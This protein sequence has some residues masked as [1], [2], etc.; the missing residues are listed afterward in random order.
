H[1]CLAGGFDLI[2]NNNCTKH[3]ITLC[4]IGDS[5]AQ[6]LLFLNAALKFVGDL[7]TRLLHQFVIP[8]CE[9]RVAKPTGN[10]LTRYSFEVSDHF[11]LDTLFA[12]VLN[13]SQRERMLAG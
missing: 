1:G 12:A 9:G 10:T 4:Q 11:R 7:S 8:K 5:L 6:T 13:R 2:R 3:A